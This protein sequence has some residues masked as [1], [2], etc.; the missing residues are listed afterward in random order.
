[1]KYAVL[2]GDGMADRPL[3]ELDGRTPLETAQTPT[4][5]EIAR[6]GQ[7]GLTR[8]IPPGFPP[9]SDIAILSILGYNPKHYYTGRAPLEAAKLGIELGPVR[10]K[11]AL[12][13]LKV[14]KAGAY[15]MTEASDELL[16]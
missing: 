4:M 16:E 13:S 5:D 7:I 2:V 6:E 15:G 10:L 14:L 3:Q 8:M 1:M 9:A 12:L 11:C